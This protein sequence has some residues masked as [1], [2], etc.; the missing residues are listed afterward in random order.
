MSKSETKA[1]SKLLSNYSQAKLIRQIRRAGVLPDSE[2]FEELMRV[3][4]SSS[5]VDLYG[6]YCHGGNSYKGRTLGQVE[7]VLSAEVE[8]SVLALKLLAC[9]LTVLRL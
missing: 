5:A 1:P 2:Y 7:L 6:F 9:V 4:F 8:V 3:I